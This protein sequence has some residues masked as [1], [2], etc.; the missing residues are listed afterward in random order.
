MNSAAKPTILAL[1]FCLAPAMAWH[2]DTEQVDSAGW[3]AHVEMRWHPDGRLFLCYS[4]TGGTIRL[5]SRDSAWSYE[6]VPRWRPMI[7][8]S[9]A[10]DIDSH[11]T[12][13][14]SY[15]GTDGRNYYALKTDTSWMDTVTPFYPYGRASPVAIDTAGEPVITIQVGDTFLLAQKLDAQWV[16]T[17][18][19]TGYASMNS[20][21]GC[22]DLGSKSDGTLWGVFVYSF[23]WPDLDIYGSSVARF[24]M[25]DSQIDVVEI[26]GG[27]VNQ[28]Y[29]CAGCVD[30]QGNVHAG[31]GYWQQAGPEGLFL[32]STQIDNV[33]AIRVA[34]QYDSQERPQIAYVTWYDTLMFRYLDSG[35]WRVF[36][37]QTTGLTAL[38]LAIDENQEPLIAYATRDG[39][40]LARGVG[41]TGQSEEK[42]RPLL[43]DWPLT[44]TVVR[45]VL[46]LPP[47]VLSPPSSLF[48]LD[49]RRV[50]SLR[51]GAND[52]SALVPGVYFLR[53]APSAVTKVVI[54]R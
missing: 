30:H 27:A 11:G 8:G 28:V 53:S 10:F 19:M 39:L 37:L 35:V 32:D 38:S 5:A 40:F 17:A 48:S 31:Y 49:G 36:D 23:N 18:L 44:A 22:T 50:M 25:Q 34:V 13:G 41:V 15:V 16:T 52:V 47:A 51:P 7:S 6:D 20:T 21:F 45:G 9:Q 12:I 1:L 26:V 42:L 33:R 24:Q 43:N 3:G 14:V 46:F 54:T 29:G 2:W 4:D